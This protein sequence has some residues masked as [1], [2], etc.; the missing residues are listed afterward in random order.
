MVASEKKV[1]STDIKRALAKIQNKD[2]TL[3]LTEVKDGATGRSGL[4]ILDAVAIKKSYTHPQITGYE[5]K[6]SR[7]DFAGDVKYA[8]YVPLCHKFYIVTPKS[9][10]K[11]EE[12]HHDV[13]LIWYDNGKLTVKK[14]PP[15]RDIEISANMRLYI[16]YSRLEADR[17]PF[18]SSE[19]EY[20]E[21][22]LENKL[23]NRDLG[24]LVKN[25]LVS[26]IVELERKLKKADDFNASG[27]GDAYDRMMD[28]LREHG[29]TR[30][31]FVNKVD[32]AHW[33]R[34]KLQDPVSERVD[35]VLSA[36]YA[37]TISFARAIERK[38]NNLSGKCATCSTM[39]HFGICSFK[40]C[41]DDSDYE[42]K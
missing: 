9:L 18:Y 26:E 3:F 19:K 41:P 8:T 11:K 40:E 24:V 2:R 22:W 23:S 36:V 25:K 39:H 13:G 29:Y 33:L 42:R 31:D 38:R 34:R 27:D 14:H 32:P 1:T 20:Y 17:I 10:V 30:A 6:I 37:Q 7:S 21:Q 35:E 15:Y 12:L 5:I 28:V 4:R 16:I